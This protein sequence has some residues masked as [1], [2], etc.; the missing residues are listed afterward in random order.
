[1]NDLHTQIEPEVH[2][3]PIRTHNGKYTTIGKL[4]HQHLCNW[5]YYSIWIYE[6]EE[7]VEMMKSELDRR[8][9]GELLSYRPKAT[10][11]YEIAELHRKG[12]LHKDG[13]IRHPNTHEFIGSVDYD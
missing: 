6:N 8:F 11:D 2:E 13:T 4:D 5:I 1:M 7:V 9:N 10:F 3:I 12:M